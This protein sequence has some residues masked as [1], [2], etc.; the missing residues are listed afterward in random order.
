MFKT[1]NLFL[2]LYEESCPNIYNYRRLTFSY[3]FFVESTQY[4]M[5]I[6]KQTVN[7]WN[8]SLQKYKEKKKKTETQQGETSYNLKI[9]KNNN[10]TKKGGGGGGGGGGGDLNPTF[11]CC[12]LIKIMFKYCIM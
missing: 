7:S 12:L 11:P 2:A 8:L 1:L 4:P 9:K 3:F 10:N 5:H 6:S